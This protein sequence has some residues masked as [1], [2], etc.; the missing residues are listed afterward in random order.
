M[1]ATTANFV[2][3]VSSERIA[4]HGDSTSSA[5]ES[6]Q[7]R[8]TMPH[9]ELFDQA[10]DS[11]YPPMTVP[12]NGIMQDMNLDDDDATFQTGLRE[13][14]A[15]ANEAR[16]QGRKR[17]MSPTAHPNN[18]ATKETKDAVKLLVEQDEA[19]FHSTLGRRRSTRKVL[20]PELL[21]PPSKPFAGSVKTS[22]KIKRKASREAAPSSFSCAYPASQFH[23]CVYRALLGSSFVCQD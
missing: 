18:G 15:I 6:P 9:L 12:E 8:P 7:V 2:D 5:V 14:V 11:A 19:T 17:N 21:E 23:S 10:L 16:D 20:V 4:A 1:I 13:A 22:E 3:T